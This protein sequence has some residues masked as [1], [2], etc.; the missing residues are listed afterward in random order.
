MSSHAPSSN[1]QNNQ[2]NG[3]DVTTTDW[4]K[5]GLELLKYEGINHITS[6]HV[7]RIIGKDESDFS[8]FFQNQHEFE[9]ALL[10]YWIDNQTEAIIRKIEGLGGDAR[11]KLWNLLDHLTRFDSDSYDP[12]IRQWSEIEPRAKSAMD[13]VNHRRIEYTE[14][15]FLEMGFRGKDADLRARTAYF[16]QVGETIAGADDSI[17]TRLELMKLRYKMLTSPFS[18]DS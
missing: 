15:L 7:A 1:D 2:N 18:I 8:R 4:L 11:M 10:Q 6:A 9:N 12:A 16:Y 5:A 14:S 13:W 17:K 3:S